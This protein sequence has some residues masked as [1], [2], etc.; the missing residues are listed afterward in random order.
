MLIIRG[1]YQINI[2]VERGVIP[3]TQFKKQKEIN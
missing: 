2:W 1:G 3:H